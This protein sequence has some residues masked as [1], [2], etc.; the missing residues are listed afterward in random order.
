MSQLGTTVSA[1]VGLIEIHHVARNNALTATMWRRLPAILEDWEQEDEVLA[2]VLRGTGGTF[3]AGADIDDVPAI[4]FDDSREDLIS[5]ATRR[6]ACFPK[7]TVAIIEGHCIGGGWELAG[8]CDLRVA[9]RSAVFGV[10][11][12][13]LGVVYPVSGVRRLVG[14]VGPGVARQLLLTAELVPAERAY[15]WGMV[16][17]LAEDS[18]IDEI[19]AG[20]V[21]T[22]LSRSQLSVRA[23]KE[24]VMLHDDPEAQ[25]AAHDRWAA[26]S[27][28][29][30][31]L[32]EGRRAFLERRAPLFPWRGTPAAAAPGKL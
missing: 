18:A 2:V 25:R 29:S 10:T 28:L 11:P 7:P 6:L 16:T 13:R 19:A 17:T 22:L 21:R 32:E 23:A 20:V 14:L 1:G 4:L 31:E 5:R 3:S 24:M 30:G 15:R 27:L 8:A 26:A 9:T 12:A